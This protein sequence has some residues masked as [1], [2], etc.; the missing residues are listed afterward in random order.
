MN[1]KKKVLWKIFIS[2]LY[3]SA[4]TFGGGYVIVTLMKK[5]FVDEYLIDLNATQAAMR[6]GYSEKTARSIGQRLLTNVDIQKYMQ[7]EQ[8]ELQERTSI[9]QEDVLRELATIGFAKIT[10]FVG[11][12]N[13]YVI[14]K[15][16][17][18]IPKDKI[19]A[20][21]SI[22][23]G[24]DGVKIRLNSKLDALEKIGRHLGMFDSNRAQETAENNLIEKIKDSVQL[25]E[26][27]DEDEVCGV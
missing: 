6:A 22:E 9:R 12:Y 10:D 13:G 27:I 8:K 16:T 23:A 20:V 18:D 26:G 19:G 21:A 25:M 7:K 1:N 24:K 14:P 4:F 5:K 11:I 15:D 3:L 17:A 2:T